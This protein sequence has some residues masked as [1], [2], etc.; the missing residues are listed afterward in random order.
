MI[1]MYSGKSPF[2]LQPFTAVNP[3]ITAEM[4]T[5]IHAGFVADPFMINRQGMWYMF[6]E[7]LKEPDNKGVIG[8]ATSTDCHEWDYDRVVLEQPFHLSYPMVF[9]YNE[10]ILMIPE[11]HSNYEICIYKA[12]NFPYNWKKYTTLIKGNYSDPTIFIHGKYCF[13]FASDRNDFLHLFWAENIYG[14]WHAHPKSP[15]VTFDP[16]RARPGGR[17]IVAGDSIIRFT[18]NC[19]HSYGWDVRAFIVTDITPENYQEKPYSNNP[20]LQGTGTGTDWNG[21][22]MHHVDLHQINKQEWLAVTDGVG[23]WSEYGLGLFGEKNIV[24][25]GPRVTIKSPYRKV[26]RKNEAEI[27]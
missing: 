18:Q 20:V 22:R 4:V 27:Q 15:I 16:E 9:Q 11:S 10:E 24:S 3:V 5:D 2:S 17:V 1:G 26:K 21:I 23:R 8:L 6:F 14:P 25:I 13:L 7:I 19:K 12:D